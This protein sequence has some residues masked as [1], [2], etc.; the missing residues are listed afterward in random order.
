MKRR[1]IALI[2]LLSLW[3]TPAFTQPARVQFV[4]ASGGGR[5]DAAFAV[6]ACARP[7]RDELTRIGQKRSL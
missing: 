3:S 1:N 2:A 7:D 4:S 6:R 5:A